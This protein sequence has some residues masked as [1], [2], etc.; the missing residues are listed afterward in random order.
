MHYIN[1]IIVSEQYIILLLNNMQLV[2]DGTTRDGHSVS[3]TS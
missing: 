1:I 3:D 2:I